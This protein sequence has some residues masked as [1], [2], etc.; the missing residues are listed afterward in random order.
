MGVDPVK[1]CWSEGMTLGFRASPSAFVGST[2][3]AIS[4]FTAQYGR[5]IPVRQVA[6]T[7]TARYQA[8]PPKIDRW[9]SISAV[10]RQ[11]KGEINRRR[12]TEREKGNKKKKR[13]KKK[14]K[15][16][17]RKE[18]KKEYLLSARGPRPCAARRSPA[19]ERRRRPRVV[20]AFSPAHGERSRRPVC[21]VHTAWYQYHTGT[22]MNSVYRYEPKD[23]FVNVSDSVS[24][25][26]PKE[27]DSWTLHDELG[28]HCED[29]ILLSA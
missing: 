20:G 12:S 26:K 28:W 25:M 3:F 24:R 8:V 6:D 14:K 10:G 16:K 9:R 1:N 11:L 23:K 7:R 18:E 17:K 27:L 13:K 4:T 5:Y 19:P 21:T 29:N 22:K 15:K 2:W